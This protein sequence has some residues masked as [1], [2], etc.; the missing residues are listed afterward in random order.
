[1]V[2][3]NQRGQRWLTSAVT[4][5]PNN[6]PAPRG[7]IAQVGTSSGSDHMRSGI[8]EFVIWLTAKGAFVWD[9]LRSGYYPDLVECSDVGG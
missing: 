4:F 1:V 6:Q 9:F 3:L 8:S 7:L 5:A 2:E